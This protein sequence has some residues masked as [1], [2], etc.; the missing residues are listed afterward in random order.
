MSYKNKTLIFES[1]KIYYNDANDSIEMEVMMDW[2]DAVM[3]KSANYVCKGGG[4][5][6]EIGFGMGISADYIQSNSITSHT[7]V[8]NHPQ[9][10]E[11][12]KAWASKKPNVTIVEGDWYT[13]KDSLS[14]YDG[15]FYDTFGDDNMDKFK[16]AL[17]NLTK[18]GSKVTWW[19]SVNSKNNYYSITGVNY[20][21][22]AVSPPSNCYFNHTTYYLPKKEF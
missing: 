8:E 22:I 16:D 12:A 14:T 11:K 21:A 2:E 15:I 7:I 18:T 3:K 10:I 6:L 17:T 13:V 4:D 9:I 20:E 1:N 19:N 5:I